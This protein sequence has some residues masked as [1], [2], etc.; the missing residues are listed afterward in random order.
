M[1]TAFLVTFAP[2]TRVVVDVNEHT[3]FPATEEDWENIY[4]VQCIEG[5]SYD[6]WFI[7]NEEGDNV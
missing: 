2:M 4:Y 7:T 5:D 1:K 3:I 6:K